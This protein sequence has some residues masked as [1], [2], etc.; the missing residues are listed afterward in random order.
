M[1]NV[2]LGNNTLTGVSTVR[3]QNADV[4]GE[5]VSFNDLVAQ[6]KTAAVTTNGTTEVTPDSGKTLSKVTITVNVPTPA[7]QLEEK[8]VTITENGTTEITPTAG[9]DGISKV[10][11]TVNVSQAVPIDVSTADEMTALLVTD[12]VGKVYRFTGT[13]DAIYTNGDLYEVVNG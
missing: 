13:T 6:E 9:K 11:A 1:A 4:A 8:A 2:K 7:P 10:T 12:N 5:Y 3:L